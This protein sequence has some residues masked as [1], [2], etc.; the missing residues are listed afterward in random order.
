MFLSLPIIVAAVAESTYSSVSVAVR[1]W[2][3]AIRIEVGI[4]IIMLLLRL[5]NLVNAAVLPVLLVISA[6][7]LFITERA[8]KRI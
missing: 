6:L 2:K 4:F 7:G 5:N 1:R 3:W 8:T